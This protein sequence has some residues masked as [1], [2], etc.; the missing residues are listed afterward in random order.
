MGRFVPAGELLP[1][2][3]P[4]KPSWW[5]DGLYYLSIPVAFVLCYPV[6]VFLFWKEA[7]FGRDIS[8]GERFVNLFFGPV[9]AVGFIFYGM[10]RWKP[11]SQEYK[12][13]YKHYNPDLPRCMHG[14]GTAIWPGKPHTI[15]AQE[16][17]EPDPDFEP[18]EHNWDDTL[19]P[20]DGLE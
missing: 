9:A 20:E 3:A 14:C 5:R 2:P 17:W 8:L 12:E 18:L 15:C 1:P 11:P 13:W 7:I 4:P 19:E 6:Y 16:P 10:A